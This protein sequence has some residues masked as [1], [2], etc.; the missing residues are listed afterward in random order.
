[1]TKRVSSCVS[2]ARGLS[3]DSRAA[4]HKVS[5]LPVRVH[6]LSLFFFYENNVAIILILFDDYYLGN[7]KAVI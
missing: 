7:T 1:M 6:R 2:S 3:K 4:V 5:L